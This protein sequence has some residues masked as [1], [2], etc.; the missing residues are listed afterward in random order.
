MFFHKSHDTKFGVVPNVLL[1]DKIIQRTYKLK[2]LDV[3]QDA[4]LSFKSYFNLVES[5]MNSAILKLGSVK[6]YVPKLAMKSMFNAYVLS[7]YDYCIEVWCVDIKLQ[8]SLY[9]FTTI[10]KKFKKHLR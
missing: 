1:N 8:L 4:T 5:R 10:S 3:I 2:Y 7:I 6:R 9:I